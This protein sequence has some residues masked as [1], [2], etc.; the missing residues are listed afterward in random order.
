MSKNL[1]IV[2]ALDGQFRSRQILM[3]EAK[4]EE[5][6]CEVQLKLELERKKGECEPQRT[7]G[8]FNLGS[9]FGSFL[10]QDM[11]P[12]KALMARLVFLKITEMAGSQFLYANIQSIGFL[13]SFKVNFAD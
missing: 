7:G 10:V 5:K 11:K 3:L 9:V 8:G 2:V 1:L 6:K 13:A 12:S 4:V